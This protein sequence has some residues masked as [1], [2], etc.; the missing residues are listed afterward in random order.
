MAKKLGAWIW[1]KIFAVC[2]FCIFVG[3]TWIT[4]K[5]AERLTGNAYA[6]TSAFVHGSGRSP[7]FLIPEFLVGYLSGQTLPV[8]EVR[9]LILGK[10]EVIG[11]NRPIVLTDTVMI[12]TYRPEEGVVRLLSLPRDL[13]IPEEGM[14]VNALYAQ[15][16]QRSPRS[17]SSYPKEVLE[18]ILG[19]RFDGVIDVSLADLEEVINLIGG[20]EVDVP[21][22]FTDPLFPRSGVDVT[23]ERDPKVLYETLHFEAGRQVL[24]GELAGKYIRSRHSENPAEGNDGA[25]TRRQQQVIEA[26]VRKVADPALITKPYFVG[27]LYAFYAQRYQRTLPITTLGSVAATLEK[28]GKIPHLEKV[29]LPLTELP[30]ATDSATVLVHPPVTK[31]KQWAYEPVDPTWNQLRAFILEKKL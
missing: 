9:Y 14:K 13:Y 23:K 18:S 4:W 2:I 3:G 7:L 10:D 30:R 21:Q 24:S 1:W 6:W 27:Q 20:V 28:S 8:T 26:I 25:R 29:S 31:Y 19:V 11:S 5:L 17:P 12:A 22:A 15:G 16:Q